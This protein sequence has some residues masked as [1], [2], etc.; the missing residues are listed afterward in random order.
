MARLLIA[1]DALFVRRVIGEVLEGAGHEVVA[2]AADGYEAVRQF[3]ETRPDVVVLD[4]NMPELD[5]IS[6]AEAIQQLEP[7]V[8]VVLASV[9][10]TPDRQ[11]R[12]AQIGALFV[13]K[14]CEPAELLAAV[15]AVAAVPA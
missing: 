8:G 5:G 6:A 15:E 9:L 12:V 11:R 2:E 13:Q 1:D 3:A 4:V 7:S 14:P 10:L